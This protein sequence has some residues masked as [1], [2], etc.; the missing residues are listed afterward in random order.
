MSQSIDSYHFK[1]KAPFNL[2]VA[3]PSGC[4]KTSWVRQLLA[5]H[6]A[7]TTIEPKQLSVVWCYGQYQAGYQQPISGV[8]IEYRE[9]LL[10]DDELN[11]SKPDIVVIDDL[12]TEMAN[13]KDL[14]NF[15]LKKGHHLGISFIF[16]LQNIFAQGSQMRNIALNGHYHCVFENKRDVEQLDR[17]IR[18]VAPKHKQFSEEM[19]KDIFKTQYGYLLV[20]CHP[21]TPAFLKFRTNIF[22]D[23]YGRTMT[24]I[25]TPK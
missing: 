10:T 6:V 12:Q 18:Q 9:G 2:I 11:Y 23:S 7:M 5:N 8:N 25:Y 14:A 1:F 20:D 15:F 17:F 3:G 21:T 16:I 13:N 19:L 4:G 22:P 24:T